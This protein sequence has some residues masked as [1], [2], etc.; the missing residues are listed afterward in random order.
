MNLVGLEKLNE[1]YFPNSP[2]RI[3]KLQRW[4]RVGELPARKIGGEWYV[5]VDEFSKQ[6]P[7]EKQNLTEHV[8]LVVDKLKGSAV[9]I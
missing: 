4:C 7:P 5:D 1:L 9:R 2:V 8:R 3:E 6:K